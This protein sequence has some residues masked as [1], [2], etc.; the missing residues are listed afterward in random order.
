MQ[1]MTWQIARLG[2]RFGLVFEPYRRRVMHSAL[3]RF[4]DE[5]MDLAVGL[6]E[7][8]GTE[9]VFPFT[10]G[11]ELLLNCEM[12][13]R[14]NSV[15][16]R[17]YSE[18]WGLRMELNIHSTFYPQHE[19]VSTMPV[20][21]MEVRVNP[22]GKVRW[23]E[24]A[25]EPPEST[26]VFVRLN[27][28]GTTIEPWSDREER[29][30]LSMR[31]EGSLVPG[32]EEMHAVGEGLSVTDWTGQGSAG[33]TATAE[34]RL[35]SLNSGATSTKLADGSAEMRLKL[36]V[37]REGSGTKW[38]LVW[39]AH[40]SDPVLFFA[41]GPG[42]SGEPRSAKDATAGATFRYAR[43]WDSVEAVAAEAI[44][45]RDDALALSRRFEKVVEQAP[46]RGAQRHLLNQSFQAFLSNTWWVNRPVGEGKTRGW[47]SAW[48]GNC[49]F[50]ATVDVE[51]NQSLM[52]LA[53]WPQLLAMQFDQWAEYATGHVAS[54]GVIVSH[55]V[56]HGPRV[57]GQAYP[58][59]M[60]VEENSN[61]LLLLQAYTRWTGDRGP[62]RRHG[63]LIQR[64]IDYLKWTDRGGTGYPTHGVA[65]TI[66]DASPA[67]Q[68]GRKQTYLGIKRAAAFSA[69]ADLL[70]LIKAEVSSAE[71]DA[72]ADD[73]IEQIERM[74]WLSDHYAVTADR[75]AVG[76]TDPWTGKPLTLD[77]LPGW[78]AYSIYTGHGLLLSQMVGR[79]PLLDA[80]RLR[81]DLRNAMREAASRY[82]C[83]HSSFEPENVWVSQNLWRDHLATYL[84]VAVPTG[85]AEGYWD[86]QV[87]SNTFDQSY[88]YIDTYV[89]NM[90]AY[91]PRGAVAFGYFLAG[92]RLVIDRLAPGERG[93]YITV[94]PPRGAS[95]RWPLLA[96]S[97]W[98]AG[99]VPVCVVDATG[100]V[101]IEGAIDPVIVHGEG[102]PTTAMGLIG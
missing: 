7:P 4:L 43:H 39:A 73:A 66:D 72:L 49:F 75:S 30:G 14:V 53:L 12:F 13:E 22:T 65:N 25:G 62:A 23:F 6:V 87:M 40:V 42:G 58:H 98:R 28:S 96:L 29:P 76:I 84:G 67:T 10:R 20:L 24:P 41:D 68:Y 86:L 83:G 31:Y 51:F 52:Y 54:G 63:D 47:F 37:T 36:P 11:G 91:Y 35:V 93:A 59:A 64:L 89:N 38:R 85:Q 100:R 33:P 102:E 48:E 81:V 21:F 74:S 16:F 32:L 97:D 99:K 3:G 27:R 17:G 9:R 55:D 45:V 70:R 18:R 56:G 77:E 90:L 80:A 46:I 26:E 101:S 94:D 78:D 69:G 79:P 95:S 61:F 92:P 19:P 82:G 1:L 5:P 88:G 15:T 2:S 44:R 50:H 60:E 71:V 57:F 34:E 8:D